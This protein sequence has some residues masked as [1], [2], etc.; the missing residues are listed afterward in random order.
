[1]HLLPM[2][3]QAAGMADDDDAL[4]PYALASRAGAT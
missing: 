1:M 3:A 2:P 4:A